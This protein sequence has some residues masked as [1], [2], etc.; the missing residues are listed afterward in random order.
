MEDFTF[1]VVCEIESIS[2]EATM[3]KFNTWGWNPSSGEGTC[4]KCID[5]KK[6]VNRETPPKD[7]TRILATWQIIYAHT[8]S[9]YIQI[10]MRWDEEGDCW[11]DDLNDE[12]SQKIKFFNKASVL[13]WQFA[14]CLKKIIA[15]NKLYTEN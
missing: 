9:E 6:Y 4:P 13:H 11:I 15:A 7:G 14:P 3:E 10:V 5:L 12:I 2:T 8:N 1:C